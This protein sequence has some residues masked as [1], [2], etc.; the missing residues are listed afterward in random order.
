MRAKN[1]LSLPTC[2]PGL[3]GAVMLLALLTASSLWAADF[4]VKKFGAKGDGKVLDTEA[5]NQAIAA[6]HNA[7]GGIVRFPAGTYLSVSI[8]LQ[9]NVGLFLEPGAVL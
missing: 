5:I 7:G 9:S 4:D 8:H 2:F 6:A 1:T 3:L